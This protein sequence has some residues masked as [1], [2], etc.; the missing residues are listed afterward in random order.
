MKRGGFI[1]KPRINEAG[2]SFNW[3]VAFNIETSTLP[4][5][6]IRLIRKAV[7]RNAYPSFSLSLKAQLLVNTQDT[8]QLGV[9]WQYHCFAMF[10]FLQK[11][12]IIG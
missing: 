7:P 5:S 6:R 2:S 9:Q 4:K 3:S 11:S 10:C 1:A 12:S 8:A